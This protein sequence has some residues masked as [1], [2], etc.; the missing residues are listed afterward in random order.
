[1]AISPTSLPILPGKYVFYEFQIAG[2][3]HSKS[4]KYEQLGKKSLF[5]AWVSVIFFTC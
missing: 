4:G 5:V 2:H 1:M 3:H